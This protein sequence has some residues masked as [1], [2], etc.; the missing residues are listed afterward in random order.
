MLGEGG[1]RFG[2]R[3]LKAITSAINSV[4]TRINLT[5]KKLVASSYRKTN[6][7]GI[8]TFIKKSPLIARFFTNRFKPGFI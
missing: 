3:F 4:E 2:G 5:V 7:E 6:F 8:E 1:G